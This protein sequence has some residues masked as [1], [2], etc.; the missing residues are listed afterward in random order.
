M[1]ASGSADGGGGGRPLP[2][3]SGGGRPLPGSVRIWRLWCPARRLRW[4]V[5]LT[6]AAGSGGLE[7]GSG[8]WSR[9]RGATATGPCPDPAAV[10]VLRPDLAAVAS[11]AT[12]VAAGGLEDRGRER[13]WQRDDSDDDELRRPG[14]VLA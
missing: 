6:A 9:W 11:G 5:G 7:S 12:V 4:Q 2:G 14:A 8:S 10:A 3:S 1:A 13:R